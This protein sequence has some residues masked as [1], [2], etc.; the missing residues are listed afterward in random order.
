MVVGDRSRRSFFP[1]FTIE[2]YGC[3]Q[4]KKYFINSVS[5]CN[6]CN[7]RVQKEMMNI[8]VLKSNNYAYSVQ[9]VCIVCILGDQL[10]FEMKDFP[11]E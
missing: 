2:I 11:P 5:D 3:A 7:E 4:L 9:K 1:N 8:I 10:S 6:V